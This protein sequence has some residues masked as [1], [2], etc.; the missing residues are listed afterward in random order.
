MAKYFSLDSYK[1]LW[2]LEVVAGRNFS[3]LAIVVRN[4]SAVRKAFKAPQRTRTKCRRQG[5]THRTRMQ[6]WLTC[7]SQASIVSD[8]ACGEALAHLC[9]HAIGG[10]ALLSFPIHGAMVLISNRNIQKRFWFSGM[11]D[12]IDKE[13]RFM[14]KAWS[15]REAQASAMIESKVGLVGDLHGI[16]GQAMPEIAA[17]D[18]PPMREGKADWTFFLPNSDKSPITAELDIAVVIERPSWR[19]NEPR[20]SVTLLRCQRVCCEDLSFVPV[21]RSSVINGEFS[22]D[23]FADEISH[24]NP[25]YDE[26]FVLD[27]G[28]QCF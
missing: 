14:V 28:H 19:P 24:P 20:Y 15:K 6:Y 22:F 21:K 5:F 10:R 3:P 23:R 26:T 11:P 8:D 2:N 12:D 17:I 4:W 25:T 7:G 27:P 1:K 9:A 18:D 13:R 16:V